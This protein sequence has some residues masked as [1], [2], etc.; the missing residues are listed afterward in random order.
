M[1]YNL[2]KQFGIVLALFGFVGGVVNGG[3]NH[4]LFEAIAIIVPSL[5]IGVF[6]IGFGALIESVHK[7]QAHLTGE[8]IQPEAEKKKITK[9]HSPDVKD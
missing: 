6:F 1:I 3:I 2:T 7:I 8:S 4:S 5:I 9:P